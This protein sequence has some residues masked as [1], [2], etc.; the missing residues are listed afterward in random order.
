[1]EE[2]MMQGTQVSPCSCVRGESS[3]ASTQL[4]T[5]IVAIQQP[6]GRPHAAS[7]LSQG[8]RK[9]A[10][11]APLPIWQR[12]VLFDTPSHST[13]GQMSMSEKR[14]LTRR[15][16]LKGAAGSMVLLAAACQPQ[17]V[18]VE[19]VVT[20]VVE[21]E[22][23]KVVTQVVEKEVEKVVTQV[24][25]VEKAAEVTGT[26]WV[27]QKKDF[28]PSMNDWFRQ[29][30]VDFCKE[31]DWPLDI[32]Y[33]AGYGRHAGDRKADRLGGCGHTC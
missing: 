27:L 33:M 3:K 17:V 29:A 15:S 6:V 25:E 28:F 26:F 14:L 23:E 30:M 24:V 5:D 2:D 16:L 31:K 1:V 7:A 12:Q 13:K 4:A 18:E 10:P 22:V 21:K 19:K 11:I 9:E 8:E 32:S 20:Q